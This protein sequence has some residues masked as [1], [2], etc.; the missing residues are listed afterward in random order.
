MP[1]VRSLVSHPKPGQPGG[2]KA[3][4]AKLSAK[5][6]AKIRARYKWRDPQHGL[7]PIADDYG[8]NVVTIFNIIRGYSWKQ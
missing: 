3:A 4:R 2:A 5:D 1:D 7:Q 6:V 8:V